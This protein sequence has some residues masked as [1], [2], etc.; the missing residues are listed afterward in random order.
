MSYKLSPISSYFRQT[1]INKLT[2]NPDLIRE[3]IFKSLLIESF[4][5]SK[6][7]RDY[8]SD[9]YCNQKASIR[10]SVLTWDE[11]TNTSQFKHV[12]SCKQHLGLISEIVE[13]LKSIKTIQ[14]PFPK[15][16]K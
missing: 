10:L 13:S 11:R 5:D 14:K 12:L 2:I 7:D 6:T 1:T 15:Q 9:L 8:C 16:T 3:E 4:V